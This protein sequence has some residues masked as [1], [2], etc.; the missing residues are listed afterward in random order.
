VIRDRASMM[1]KVRALSS[2]GRMTAIMLTGLPV[3]AFIL[4]FIIRPGFYLDVA[5]D[6][7][8]I[9]GFAFLLI[10]YAIGF[11]TIRRMVDLKV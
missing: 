3:F 1:M 9:P 4:L 8:F 2:E 10:L 5:D 11:I 7:A 6:P